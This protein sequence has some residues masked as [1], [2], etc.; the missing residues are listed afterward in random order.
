[1]YYS[2]F[3]NGLASSSAPVTHRASH[4]LTIARLVFCGFVIDRRALDQL[5][6]P[7]GKRLE[8][9]LASSLTAL[10]CR[11]VRDFSLDLHLDAGDPRVDIGCSRNGHPVATIW[12]YGRIAQ[13][14]EHVLDR[15]QP[16]RRGSVG[17]FAGALVLR[18]LNEK[19]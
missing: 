11:Q 9:R 1:M 18:R 12:F 13:H 8:D 19:M 14:A 5:H 17:N 4:I 7:L 10:F 16:I 6:R 2:L 15:C 3:N